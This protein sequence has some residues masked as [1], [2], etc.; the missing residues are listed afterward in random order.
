MSHGGAVYCTVINSLSAA[1]CGAGLLMCFLRQQPVEKNAFS[2]H[3]LLE[4]DL[5]SV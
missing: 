3:S 5:R 4:T 1:V 2:E